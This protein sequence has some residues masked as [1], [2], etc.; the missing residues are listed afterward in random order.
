MRMRIRLLPCL[1]ALA[2]SLVGT[3][4]AESQDAEGPSLVVMISI[5]QLRGD[6][7]DHFEEA[8]TGGFRRFLDEGFRFTS[9]SHAHAVTHTAPGHATLSTGVFPSRSGIVANNWSQR[10]GGMWQSMYAVEDPD[11]PILDFE[12]EEQLP[13]RSPK[14][15]LRTGLADWVRAA[16]DDS[17][18][19]SIS[20]KDRSAITMAGQTDSNVYWLVSQLG[21]FVTSTFYDDSYDR[22]VERFNENEMPDIIGPPVWEND[23][24]E[25]FRGLA[26]ADSA[27]YEGR[28][29]STF[30]HERSLEAGSDSR[31]AGKA[32]AL[33]TSRA[34]AAVM[35]LARA[36]M[37]NFDLGQ[38][39]NTDY[40][41][42]S[43][44]ATDYVG[45]G[46]GPFS[47]EQLVN[48]RHVD[49][50]LGEFFDYLD[51]EVGE[52][53]WVVGLSADHGV[54]TMPEYEQERGNMSAERL[55]PAAEGP[56]VTAAL[57]AASVGGGSPEE[58]AERLARYLEREGIA[59]KAYT[60]MELTR[61]QPADSFAV[62]Y[63]NSHY[64]GRAHHAMSV[65]GVEFRYPEG[66][67]VSFPTGTTHGTAYWYDR[68]VPLMFLGRGVSAGSSGVAA[69][70]VDIAP[71]L[72]ALA[73]I[74]AP[75]DLDGRAIIPR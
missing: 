54:V 20:S 65:Y 64:P 8:F 7:I 21:R 59:E 68:H 9:A 57:E 31:Q 62:M 55:S 23:T 27:S 10:V 17:R 51:S 6:L 16:D 75:S 18:T 39:D 46:Y 56:K 15:L 38:R 40:L 30:P 73:G 29:V 42:I 41:A 43:L 32:W 37:E 53:Q 22:W 66:D 36:A 74:A 1:S 13:G 35:G 47:Q 25:R 44:S 26:R 69:Y 61:G 67:L 14:N 71:T 11:H 2:L 19:V 34:D 12:N 58:I 52:G 4:P 28:G 24:P 48:L 60:H 70:T 33:G 3:A 50:I 5:D 72:A 63:R 49:R 45:H